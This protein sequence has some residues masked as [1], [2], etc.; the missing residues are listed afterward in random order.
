MLVAGLARKTTE[1]NMQIDRADR[2]LEGSVDQVFEP[3]AVPQLSSARKYS[4]MT[5]N[6]QSF[7]EILWLALGQQP[8]QRDPWEG[9]EDGEKGEIRER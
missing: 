7:H 2:Q 9:M 3:T 8:Y 4:A 1:T 5:L 6:L